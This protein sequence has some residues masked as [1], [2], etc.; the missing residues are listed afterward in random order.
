[1]NTLTYTYAE[2]YCHNLKKG[3]SLTEEEILKGSHMVQVVDVN[4]KKIKDITTVSDKVMN[5]TMCSMLC[6]FE[7]E[8]GISIL[9]KYNAFF[10]CIHR[11]NERH[12]LC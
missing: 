2:V 11:G 9:N 7:E 1:M 8:T 5:D 4:N 12:W 10:F 3:Q 6:N